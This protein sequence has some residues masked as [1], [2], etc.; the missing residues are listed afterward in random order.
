MKCE[1]GKTIK[2][3]ILSLS[4][5]P[6]RFLRI[7]WEGLYVALSRVKFK[8]DIRLLLRNGDRS[9][10]AYIEELEK[11]KLVKS[12]FKG[13]VS[14]TREGNGIQNNNEQPGLMK[15]DGEQASMDAGFL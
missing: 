2:K 10:M 9:T 1:K 13:Y 14:Y 6:E 15:W 3:V 4:L 5:H 7:R 8:D 11:N 12:F